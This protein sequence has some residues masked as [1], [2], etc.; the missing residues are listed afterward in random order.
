[1]LLLDHCSNVDASEL[2]CTYYNET[3][4]KWESTGVAPHG[5]ATATVGRGTQ[6]RVTCAALHATAFS[7]SN[8]GA[9][10]GTPEPMK[11]LSDQQDDLYVGAGQLCLVAFV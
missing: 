11:S 5:T 3:T 4:K 9:A 10:S 2:S 7:V 1:M 6:R 8:P